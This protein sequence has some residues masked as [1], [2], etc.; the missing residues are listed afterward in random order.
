M[1]I[2]GQQFN[3]LERRTSTLFAIEKFW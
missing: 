3:T 1:S 2:A